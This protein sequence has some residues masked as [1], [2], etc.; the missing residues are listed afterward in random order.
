MEFRIPNNL[1][2]TSFMCED[3]DNI[4][5]DTNANDCATCKKNY[6]ECWSKNIKNDIIFKCRI[7]NAIK[8]EKMGK[9]P[10]C[11]K[12]GVEV[13]VYDNY[14]CTCRHCGKI[15]MITEETIKNELGTQYEEVNLNKLDEAIKTS[16][17]YI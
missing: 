2:R 4:C 10:N 14:E 16:L 17:Q 9:C 7:N 3:G 11:G 8:Y 1:K 12:Y 6:K 5:S 15:S 13:T